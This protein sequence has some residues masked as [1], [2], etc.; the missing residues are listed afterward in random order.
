LR[1]QVDSLL[2]HGYRV[3]VV[4]R[5][6]ECN[7]IYRAIPRLRLLEYPG[8]PEATGPLEYAAS[9]LAGV[10]LSR[11]A[12]LRERV[13]VVQ[14]W[15]PPDVHFPLAWSLRAFGCKI[16]I[17]QRDLVPE[18]YVARFGHVH[19]LFVRFFDRFAQWNYGAADR[20]LCVNGYLERY[21]LAR[22][23]SPSAV[24]IVRSGPVLSRVERAI[25]TPALRR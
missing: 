20:V 23:A 10:V 14:F 1:K 8:P 9:L 21:A 13:D 17:D 19:P 7:R 24:R 6:D 25:A 3:S 4:T 18:L 5:R 11:R 16:L 2:E 22:G 12:C 15:Q